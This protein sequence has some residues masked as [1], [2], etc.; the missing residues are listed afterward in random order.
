MANFELAPV[1][2]NNGL[3]IGFWVDLQAQLTTAISVLGENTAPD[4]SS[5]EDHFDP[6]ENTVTEL[7]T[8]ITAIIASLKA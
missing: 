3:G 7:M 6:D 2:M 1:P 4:V 5:D 8:G